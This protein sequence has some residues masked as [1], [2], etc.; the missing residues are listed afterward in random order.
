MSVQEVAFFEFRKRMARRTSGNRFVNKMFEFREI[1]FL[2]VKKKKLPLFYVQINN[3]NC[4][5]N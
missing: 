4:A 1:F 5:Q 3:L 2:S